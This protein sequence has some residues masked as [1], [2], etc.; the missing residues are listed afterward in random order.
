M[1]GLR[2]LALFFFF[3]TTMCL[4][5]IVL[6]AFPDSVLEPL[7]RLNPGA[8]DAFQS[9]GNWAFAMMAVVGTACLLSAI[10]L[11][12][13]ATWGRALAIG[14][15]SINLIG[16]IAGAIVRSDPRTLIGLPIA[17]LMIWYLVKRAPATAPPLRAP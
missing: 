7:W 2:F 13:N 6:L 9:M 5:T 11:L 8:R 17:G 16:D 4:L 15:L 3:G 12:R 10:G 14:V 1:N